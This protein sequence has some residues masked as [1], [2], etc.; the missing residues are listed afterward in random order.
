MNITGEFFCGLHYK[1]MRVHRLF[2]IVFILHL[3]AIY[4]SNINTPP[5]QQPKFLRV[6][7]CTYFFRCSRWNYRFIWKIKL[8]LFF[9][10]NFWTEFRSSWPNVEQ[11]VQNNFDDMLEVQ[12][13]HC[14]S[15][16]KRKS[17][18]V[19]CYSTP[20]ANFCIVIWL[21]WFIEK[22]S[23]VKLSNRV[24]PTRTL[25]K[26]KHTHTHTNTSI[27]AAHFNGVV[28][29]FHIYLFALFL[30]APPYNS[31]WQ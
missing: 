20:Y 28:A 12:K 27:H 11:I 30:L 25:I 16:I 3:T 29:I 8:K 1:R 10:L 24:C 14:K 4:W 6:C 21:F 23:A 2:R 13:F 7:L 17:T 19:L 22:S 26:C 18:D 15:E 9:F 31:L 5:K